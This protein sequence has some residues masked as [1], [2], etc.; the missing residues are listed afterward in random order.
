MLPGDDFRVEERW[1][2]HLEASEQ[3][4]SEADWSIQGGIYR[5]HAG[6]VS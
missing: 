1:G 3:N 4:V 6:E 2:H 5:W